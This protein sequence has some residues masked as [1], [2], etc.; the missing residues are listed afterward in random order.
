MMYH[1]G[2]STNTVQANMG[3]D[4]PILKA[5]SSKPKRSSACYT[6]TSSQ[7][8][9]R[10]VNGINPSNPDASDTNLCKFIAKYLN[11]SSSTTNEFRNPS[12]NLYGIW[13]YSTL[14]DT[15]F[16]EY[17]TSR[18]TDNNNYIYIFHKAKCNGEAPE[19]TGMDRNFAATYKLE[20][21]GVYCVNNS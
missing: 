11:S 7:P 8:L 20:G 1:G 2:Y 21:A 6:E 14:T 5:T 18:N 17:V 9:N 10:R 15:G 16:N 13:A 12:G 4:L 3:A 19:W